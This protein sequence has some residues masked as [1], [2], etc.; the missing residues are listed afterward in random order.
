MFRK[1]SILIGL[2][3]VSLA[4]TAFSGPSQAAG[5]PGIP[6]WVWLLIVLVLLALFVWWLLSGPEEKE[7]PTAE[8]A[9]VAEMPAPDDLMRIEG[10]GPRI[11]GLLQAAGI[12]TFG[13]LAATDVN[14]L[15][16]ILKAADITVADPSTWPEQASLASAGRWD[17][18]ETLQ[19]ELKGGRRA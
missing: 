1:F 4:L 17:E 18:L 15:S 2:L 12:T 6:S 13:Q 3:T 14:R 19:D 8:A 10:I 9:P 5:N 7:A 16:E 11:S